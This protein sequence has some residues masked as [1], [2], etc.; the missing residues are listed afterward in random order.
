MLREE[1]SKL[2]RDVENDLAAYFTPYTASED[3]IER[4]PWLK[5]F[6]ECIAH[7]DVAVSLNYDCLF[8]GVLDWMERWTPTGGYG[9]L[10]SLLINDSVEQSPVSVLKI[11]GSTSFIIVPPL[12]KSQAKSIGFIFD[13]Q[14][15][16]RS[17]KNT[18]HGYGMGLGQPYLI[19]P[20]YVKL[21]VV[22]IA[23]FMLGALE[24][25][26][27][28][29][30]LVVVGCSLRP[31]DVFLT[32]VMTHFLRQSNWRNRRIIILDLNAGEIAARIR[33]YWPTD[34]GQCVVP[35]EG[36][37]EESSDKLLKAIKQERTE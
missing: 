34:I 29:E 1:L 3:I 8:E 11:H 35:I 28:S 13:E 23:Y 24:A 14:F 9:F 19:A 5:G 22:E 16:P 25:V 7:G 37:I 6:V 33:E 20:S 32:L 36:R 15:F 17:A 2:R 26:G 18:H 31:E 27:R 12:G 10:R 30:N 4:L 21:P